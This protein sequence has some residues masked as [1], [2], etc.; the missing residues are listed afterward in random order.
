MDGIYR[1]LHML[2]PLLLGQAVFIPALCHHTA[3]LVAAAPGLAHIEGDLVLCS[4]GGG[5]I[6]ETP[7]PAGRNGG[8]GRIQKTVII[9]GEITS[10]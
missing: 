4:V 2:Q 8:D 7:D 6:E 10:L 1:L 3:V 5:Q 9:H